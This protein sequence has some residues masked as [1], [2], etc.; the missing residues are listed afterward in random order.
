ML[1]AAT[2]PAWESSTTQ[3][4]LAGVGTLNLVVDSGGPLSPRAVL[5]PCG[6]TIRGPH[7][8]DYI[9]VLA[10]RAAL[11]PAKTVEQHLTVS[12][13]AANLLWWNLQQRELDHVSEALQ[14]N[15]PLTLTGAQ[16]L[17]KR[18]ERC[19]KIGE[20][21]IAAG[22]II[23]QHVISRPAALDLTSTLDYCQVEC[24]VQVQRRFSLLEAQATAICLDPKT[25]PSAL[26]QDERQARLSSLI[27]VCVAQQAQVEQ[28]M[29]ALADALARCASANVVST[30]ALLPL[31]ILLIAD[32]SIER[33][34]PQSAADPTNTDALAFI[35][36]HA[37]PEILCFWPLR[38]AECASRQLLRERSAGFEAV[39]KRYFVMKQQR[40]ISTGSS[41]RSR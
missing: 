31:Q 30:S 2:T 7:Y 5:A 12:Y 24:F 34:H 15:Q 36:A 20:M 9:G 25:C 16:D 41:S 27:A 28:D 37:V 1:Q 19:R 35:Y 23:R 40:P 14:S 17:E 18:L 10:Y 6:H 3:P 32:Q 13:L 11:Y 26:D 33:Y 8:C 4:A 38:L 29:A 21:Q 39:V 22:A